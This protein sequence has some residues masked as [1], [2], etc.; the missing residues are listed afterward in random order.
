V[1]TSC[2]VAEEKGKKKGGG[3]SQE[4]VTNQKRIEG[5]LPLKKMLLNNTINKRYTSY[6][7]GRKRTKKKRVPK[8]KDWG[9][10]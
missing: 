1:T 8:Q 9:S 2:P 7:V 10:R 6:T 5:Y 4:G 3:D